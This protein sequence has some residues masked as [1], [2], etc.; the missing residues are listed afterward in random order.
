MDFNY[1]KGIEYRVYLEYIE[2]TR[3]TQSTISSGF[4]AL[5]DL[6]DIDTAD[7][8]YVKKDYLYENYNQKD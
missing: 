7:N 8:N 1:D 6:L 5:D 2:D 4:V 3:E